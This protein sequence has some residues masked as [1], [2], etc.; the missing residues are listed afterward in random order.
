MV[1]VLLAGVLVWTAAGCSLLGSSEAW[2]P[3][4]PHIVLTGANPEV[5]RLLLSAAAAGDQ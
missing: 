4:T 3:A 2:S 5:E 1:R